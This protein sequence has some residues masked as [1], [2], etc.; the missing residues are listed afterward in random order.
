MLADIYAERLRALARDYRDGLPDRL[1]ALADHAFE[2][3]RGAIG[4]QAAARMTVHQLA[5][6]ARSFGCPAL[7][8]A[9]EAYDAAFERDEPVDF[10]RLVDDLR[11]A[12][13]RDGVEPIA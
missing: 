1:C 10:L 3:A 11:A 9:C 4:S 5:G 7:A 8:D 6:T 13:A 2:A 12:A